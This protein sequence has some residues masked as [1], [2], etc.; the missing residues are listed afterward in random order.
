MKRILIAMALTGL[1]GLSL[2]ASTTPEVP[3]GPQ[4]TPPKLVVLVVIDQLSADLFDRYASVYTGG[5]RRLLD[6]GFVFTNAAHA[7]ANTNTAVGHAAL[8]TAVYPYRNGIVD[9]SW[10]EWR[11]GSWQSVYA[12][13]DP[14]SPI[15]GS[16]ALPGRSPANLEASGIGDWMQK[17]N[18]RSKVVSISRKDRAA[19]TLAGQTADA[20]VYW[21]VPSAARWVTST[22]YRTQYS[23]WFEAWH[24][25]QLPKIFKDSVWASSIPA[26]LETLSWPDTAAFEGDGVHTYFPHRY[27]DEVP[28]SVRSPAA[29]NAWASGTP[30]VDEATISLTEEAIRALDLGQDDVPDYLGLALS[31]TDIIGH[32][33][34][35]YSREQL[36]NLLRLDQHLGEFL[37]FLDRYVGEGNW[38]LGLSA[39]HGI[40][41]TPEGLVAE[42]QWAKRTTLDEIRTLI[43]DARRAV[44]A[45]DSA[46]IPER[47]KAA[48]L[49]SDWIAAAYTDDELESGEPA[50]S[51][52]VLFRHSLRRDRVTGFF[53][54]FG[55]EVRTLP[56]VLA[57]TGSTGTSHGS[58]YWYDRHVPMI[59]LG[60]SVHA[61]SSDESVATVDMATTLAHLAGVAT[62]TDRDG[63]ALFR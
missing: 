56:Y 62:P 51:F 3:E 35:P 58:P 15:A 37:D 20:Q 42:G 19:I 8:S 12:V 2:V 25:N 31:Q 9:N 13:E 24:T 26:D 41:P 59:F 28:D 11:Q 22:Y 5:F 49:K 48:V 4:Q 18:P 60:A 45:G 17:Q 61:G 53:G 29:Y 30:M 39:D 52:A 23:R 21:L 47:V 55:V 63:R 46:G 50:D 44:A 14:S 32:G 43:T 10:A 57:T 38:L 36:D 40:L 27:V 7:H 33:F 34:G 6:Q 16:S 54:E 1:L